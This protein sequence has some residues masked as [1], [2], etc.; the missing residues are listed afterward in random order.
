MA[1]EHKPYY[2]ERSRRCAEQTRKLARRKRRQQE[3]ERLTRLGVDPAWLERVLP[4]D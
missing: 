1:D 3:R 4:L 2:S